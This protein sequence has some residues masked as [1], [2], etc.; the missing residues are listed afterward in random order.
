MTPLLPARY[1]IGPYLRADQSGQLSLGLAFGFVMITAMF[2]LVLSVMLNVREKVKLQ[3]T[4]DFAA[5]HAANI[6][7]A[8]LN[9][10]RKINKAI[11]SLW[12]K[13]LALQQINHCILPIPSP[14][15]VTL[16]PPVTNPAGTP[17][18]AVMGQIAKNLVLIRAD[19]DVIQ[20]IE[21]TLNDLGTQSFTASNLNQNV[22][23]AQCN[24]YQNQVNKWLR[25]NYEQQ[26]EGLMR[27]IAMINREANQAARFE[28]LKVFMHPKNMPLGLWQKLKTLLGEGF[29]TE[30]AIDAYVSG[31]MDLNANN[32]AW[33]FSINGFNGDDPLFEA[34]VETRPFMLPTFNYQ[35]VTAS[36]VDMTCVT[37]PGVRTY[38][39]GNREQS[40]V[41]V[42]RSSNY[43]THY[44][45]G[46][47]YLPPKRPF[48]DNEA[49]SK[50]RVNS[51]EPDTFGRREERLDNPALFLRSNVNAVMT[52]A[53]AKPFGGNLP[54]K[55]LQDPASLARQFINGFGNELNTAT[56][57]AL[58]APFKGARLFGIADARQID[59]FDIAPRVEF[60]Q[61]IRD[62]AGTVIERLEILKQDYLH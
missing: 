4:T 12:F 37:T 24:T 48:E 19:R 7:S 13:T 36:L 52:F 21:Q 20:N 57:N 30:Q 55:L 43:R 49:L 51:A 32:N 14:L 40:Q 29:S 61:T 28:S 16:I 42:I 9:E 41:K 44:L 53:A 58:G 50:R 59:G 54:V 5:I 45:T 3:Q 27:M 39:F 62:Q 31:L 17:L 33:G 38:Q 8:Y 47:N 34:E 56:E 22:C 26:R 15:G 18:T 25:N 60:E 46:A 11:E 35:L 10:I 6:Q 1:K 23:N 2:A